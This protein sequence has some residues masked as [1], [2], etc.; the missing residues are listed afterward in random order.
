MT[1]TRRTVDSSSILKSPRLTIG[2]DFGTA[3]C[4]V[5]WHFQAKSTKVAGPPRR[6]DILMKIN[7][8]GRWPGLQAESVPT[9]LSYVTPNLKWG[10]Q[11]KEA[12][13]TGELVDDASVVRQIKLWLHPCDLT[14]AARDRLERQGK[15]KLA[16]PDTFI[17]DFLKKVLQ[18]TNLEIK[19]QMPSLPP[20]TTTCYTLAVPPAW[21]EHEQEAFM[22]L[23]FKA[24]IKDATLVSEP[25]A[26]TAYTMAK[27]PLTTLKVRTN[28]H[29][30]GY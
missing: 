13:T 10:G 26:V 18:N 29:E 15:A 11:I 3:T 30:V 9:E 14:R 23:A 19:K 25:E 16:N 28:V 1:K 21:T 6:D 7:R 12:F 2:I 17:V 27:A 22:G 8:I 20:K 4:A 24:G 5:C